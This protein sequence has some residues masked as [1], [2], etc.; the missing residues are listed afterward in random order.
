MKLVT[1]CLALFLCNVNGQF[2]M[3]NRNDGAKVEDNLQEASIGVDGTVDAKYESLARELQSAAPISAEDALHIAILLEEAKIDA[4]TAV[5]LSQM[6]KEAVQELKASSTP[7]EI[8][9][10]LKA[11]LHELKAVEILFSNPERAVIEMEK[12]GLIEK[13]RVDF[14]KKNPSVLKDDTNKAIY[15]AFVSLAA[16]GGYL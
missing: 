6:P 13:K 4:E 5:L 3:L 11:N 15:F 9:N 7:I 12:E 2:G 8:V 14:Y 10:G 16:A 1:F